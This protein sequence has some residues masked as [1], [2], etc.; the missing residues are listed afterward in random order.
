MINC[1]YFE[2]KSKLI[3]LNQ[4][5]WEKYSF[6]GIIGNSEY[7]V[8]YKGKNKTTGKNYAIKEINK[9]KTSKENYSEEMKTINSLNNENSVLIIEEIE[10]KDNYYIIMELCTSNLEEYIKNRNK[11][12]STEEIKIIL[13]ELNKALKKMNELK[14]IHGNITLSN[15]LLSIDQINKISIKLSDYGLNESLG[16]NLKSQ[17]YLFPN[18]TNSPEIFLCILLYKLLFYI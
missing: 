7:G 18:Y 14:I 9:L 12:L 11:P 2:N 13:I 17:S 5:I 15:I 4:R 1:L 3:M 6:V 10:T 16:N 8:V